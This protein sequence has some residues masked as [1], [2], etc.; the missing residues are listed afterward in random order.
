MKWVA[1]E[2]AAEVIFVLIVGLLASFMNLKL[3]YLVI[4]VGA[5][6]FLLRRRR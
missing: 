5:G 4:V 6:I 3:A 1:R 2:V